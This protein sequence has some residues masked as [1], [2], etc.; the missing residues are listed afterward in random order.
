MREREREESTELNWELNQKDEF[1]HF[2][3]SVNQSVF[4]FPFYKC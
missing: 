3:Y 2:D 4:I 1:F